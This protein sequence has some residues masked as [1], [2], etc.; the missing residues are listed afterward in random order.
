MSDILE[1]LELY[2]ASGPDQNMAA[3]AGRRLVEIL[4]R[5]IDEIKTLRQAKEDA[6]TTGYYD[7]SLSEAELHVGEEL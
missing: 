5:A 1:D 2:L 7:G 4:E 3:S 6:Y